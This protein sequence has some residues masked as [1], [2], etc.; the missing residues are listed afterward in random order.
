MIKTCRN[1]P[2][3]CKRRPRF[4]KVLI[5]AI[6]FVFVEVVSAARLVLSSAPGAAVPPSC[7]SSVNT[8]EI[9]A[10]KLIDVFLCIL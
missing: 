10:F 2:I 4:A 7:F 9:A 8:R 1:I 6:K 5:A 3:S